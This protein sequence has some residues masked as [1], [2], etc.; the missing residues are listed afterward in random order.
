[1][2][3]TL[4]ERAWNNLREDK[5][6]RKDLRKMYAEL[7]EYVKYLEGQLN[8]KRYKKKEEEDTIMYERNIRGEK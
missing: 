3:V 6:K 5:M 2:R 1:M 8:I 4:L 7:L